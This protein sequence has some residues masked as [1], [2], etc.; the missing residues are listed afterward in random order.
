MSA[1]RDLWPFQRKCLIGFVLML[2]IVMGGS[3]EGQQRKKAVTLEVSKIDWNEDGRLSLQLELR[4]EEVAAYYSWRGYVY[5][6][7]GSGLF[8]EIEYPADERLVI[9]SAR[10]V[11]PKIPHP[12]DVVLAKRY[13]YPKPL[14]VQVLRPDG[15]IYQGCVRFRLRYDTRR[16]STFSGVLASIVARS[17][18]L[19]VCN[20]DRQK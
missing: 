3:L 14:V 6:L 11:L 5:P 18:L 9:V 19:E 12:K 4:S 17:D 10:K 1:A 16:L 2:A 13:R 8:F 7:L 20:D 15:S